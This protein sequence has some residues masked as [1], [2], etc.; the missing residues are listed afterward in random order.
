MIKPMMSND[1]ILFIEKNL[2]DDKTMLEW[3]SGNS[4]IYFSKFVKELVSIEHNYEWYLYVKNAIK[5]YNIDNIKLYYVEPNEKVTIP[6]VKSQLIDY[7]E[8]PKT[9]NIIFDIVLI[10]GRARQHCAYSILDYIKEN[11]LL[12]MHDFYDRT[13]YHNV[14]DIYD[15]VDEITE[16]AG[17]VSL[18]K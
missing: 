1:E 2:N 10:D 8:F 3:G 18:M 5:W 7:I 4:T 16:G 9:L 12:F 15:K 14:L 17:I 13:R 6:S 11:G